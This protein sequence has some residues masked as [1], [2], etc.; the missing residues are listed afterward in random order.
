MLLR[1]AQLLTQADGAQTR[2]RCRLNDGTAVTDV[3][4]YSRRHAHYF[5]T[6]K[7]E[8]AVSGR[9]SLLSLGPRE[10]LPDNVGY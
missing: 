10:F 2:R 1:V 5:G 6:G 7:V 9:A 4:I 3:L 8:N